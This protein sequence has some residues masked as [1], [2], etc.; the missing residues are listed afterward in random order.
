MTQSEIEKA[1]ERY[2][3][4]KTGFVH[5][6]DTPSMQDETDYMDWCS[7]K[8]DFLAGA[9]HA[10]AKWVSTADETPRNGEIVLIPYHRTFSMPAQYNLDSQGKPFWLLWDCPGSIDAERTLHFVTQWMRLP[11][12]PEAESNE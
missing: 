12:S 5:K 6:S 4:K 1:A 7:A 11:A 9:E 2:A 3:D 8:E 10:G